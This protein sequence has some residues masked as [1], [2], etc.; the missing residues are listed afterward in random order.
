MHDIATAHDPV[1][2]LGNMPATSGQA[3]SSV[4][5]VGVTIAIAATAPSALS[6]S[7]SSNAQHGSDGEIF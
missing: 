3:T 7:R 5:A 2:T 6:E 1:Q 4:G